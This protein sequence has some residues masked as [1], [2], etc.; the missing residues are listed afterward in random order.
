MILDQITVHNNSGNGR[1]LE[2]VRGNSG[3]VAIGYNRLP[4]EYT[5]PT[6][7]ISN[8]NF[9]MNR[10]FGF[11]APERAVTAKV[12]IGRGGGM[13]LFINE[14]Y[15][16]IHAEITNCVFENNKARLFGGGL[17]ILTTSY[18]SVQH[19]ISV[20]R[21]R[22]SGNVAMFGGG[23]IQQS[24]LSGGD[25]N[26]PHSFTLSDCTFEGNRGQSGGGAYIFI[27]LSKVLSS[28]SLNIFVYT[29]R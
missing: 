5:D 4:T 26:R 21:T 15:Q 6:L 19:V 29:C 17:Y 22:F 28:I 10:A 11:L 20:Q 14:S 12:Y 8:S 13:A 9:T 25:V 24:F 1:F 7:T 16:D 2:T 18:V 23:G 3:G 27:G